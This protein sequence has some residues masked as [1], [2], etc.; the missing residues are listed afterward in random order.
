MGQWSLVTETPS[1]RDRNDVYGHHFAITFKLKYTASMMGS[2]IE[3][4]VLE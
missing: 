3:S 2:F 4:P 1:I